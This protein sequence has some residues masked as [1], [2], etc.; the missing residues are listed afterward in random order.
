MGPAIYRLVV[1]TSFSALLQPLTA[2]QQRDEAEGLPIA[3]VEVI[4]F[5]ANGRFLGAPNVTAFNSATGEDI[6][7]QF[8]SGVARGIP[9]GVYR[10][11]AKLAGYFSDTTYAR[12]YRPNVTLVMGLRF[13]AELPQVPPTL[14]GRVIG[15]HMQG[16][17]F[18]KMIGVF[19]HTSTESAIDQDG[20][21][22][23]SGLS[24]GRYI[25]LIIGEKGVMASKTLTIP[26]TGP[27]LEMKIQGEGPPQ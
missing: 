6:S 26:Y 27:P 21:F 14:K 16:K 17:Y 23:M 15:L 7:S 11:E 9:Y 1:F 20:T 12:V 8:H 4:S 10:I 5:E 25:L 22:A 13:G 3:N 18:A 19:E 24:S 2:F